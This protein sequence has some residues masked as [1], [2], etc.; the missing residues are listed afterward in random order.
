MDY[1]HY[2]IENKNNKNNHSEKLYYSYQK[3]VYTYDMLFNDTVNDI[4]NKIITC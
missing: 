2:V 3:N 1:N 4:K